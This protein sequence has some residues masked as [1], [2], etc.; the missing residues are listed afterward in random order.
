MHLILDPIR[1][2]ASIPQAF[3][4]LL[5]KRPGSDL[6]DGRLRGDPG[7]LVAARVLRIPTVLWD[8][9]VV[10]GSERPGHRSPRERGGRV[11]HRDL[12]GPGADGTVR[13]HPMTP[14]CLTTGT[15]IRDF[16]D[17]DPLAARER[18]GV[19]GGERLL[20]IFGGSQAVRR[21]NDAVAEALP[22]ARRARCHVLHVTGDDGYAAAL[23]GRETLP[24][25]LRARYRPTR[26]CAT[27]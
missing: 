14:P 2:G 26:S 18:L 20:L 6:H 21:L 23:A 10:P 5:R 8:G 7:L 11:V 3:L 25:E 16:R 9:N 12:C 17:V 24:S 13:D 15:P 4:M 27:R 19:P 22:R 1:L